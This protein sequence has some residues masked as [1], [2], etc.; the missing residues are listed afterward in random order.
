M[1][2]IHQVHHEWSIASKG[3]TGYDLMEAAD[4]FAEQHPDRVF[5]SRIDDTVF[6]SSTLMLL[7]NEGLDQNGDPEFFGVSAYVIPQNSGEP[8]EFFMYPQHIEE[9]IAN[10]QSIRE[11]M[12][13]YKETREELED[14]REFR[15]SQKEEDHE[16]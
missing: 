13:E 4:A 11:K 15:N 1:N 5:L 7:T 14:W 3:K 16:G 9:L 6:S 2:T 8:Q 12:V 10:L